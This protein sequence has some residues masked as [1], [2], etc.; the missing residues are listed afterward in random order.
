MVEKISQVIEQILGNA[1]DSLTQ[2]MS[3]KTLDDVT[4]HDFA[5]YEYLIN[6]ADQRKLNLAPLSSA[7]VAYINDLETSGASPEI[8]EYMADLL[9]RLEAS[10]RQA[11]VDGLPANLSSARRPSGIGAN[12]PVLGSTIDNL[13]GSILKP[14]YTTHRRLIRT[15]VD[16][17]REIKDFFSFHIYNDIRSKAKGIALQLTGVF[18]TNTSTYQKPLYDW[19]FIIEEINWWYITEDLEIDRVDLASDLEYPFELYPPES[20]NVGIALVY[21]QRWKAI[22][23]QP[24]EIIKTIPLGPG[25]SE[26]V[27]TKITQRRKSTSSTETMVE[28]EISTDTSDTTKD[29]TEVVKEAASN[30]NWSVSAQASYGVGGV[31]LV[32]A[33]A[34][35]WA[36]QNPTAAKIQQRP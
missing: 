9:I 18:A 16:L 7:A 14:L 22:G 34:Q 10:V 33:P 20:V 11:C 6:P 21:R 5:K 24:G 4:F 26:K 17:D 3:S 31:G 29:S 13:P 8:L 27:V 25:Q 35:K 23:T 2:S 30:Q 19:V 36:D 15:I 1:A 28:S 32:P 12:L